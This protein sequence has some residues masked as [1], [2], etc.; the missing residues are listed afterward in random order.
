MEKNTDLGEDKMARK[1]GEG[2]V[3]CPAQDGQEPF[4]HLAEDLVLGVE[5]VVGT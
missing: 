5:H 4:C 2:L 1:V 3:W